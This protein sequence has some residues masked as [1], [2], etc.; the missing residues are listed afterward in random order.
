MCTQ[1]IMFFVDDA[2]AHC[3]TARAAGA[4][5]IDEPATH[6]Y[7]E[8]YWTKPQ[9]WSADPEGHVWWDHPAPEETADKA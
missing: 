5:I 9:L 6:N 3:E 2:D 1:H 7:G 8:D 4:T